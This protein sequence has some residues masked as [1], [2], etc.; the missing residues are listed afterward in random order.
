MGSE[1]VGFG[2]K[3]R[4]RRK[5]PVL[6]IPIIQTILLH[7]TIEAKRI[8]RAIEKSKISAVDV[9]SCSAKTF[10]CTWDGG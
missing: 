9:V 7:E 10:D 5:R 4:T 3:E 2:A 1:E 6:Q 8:V